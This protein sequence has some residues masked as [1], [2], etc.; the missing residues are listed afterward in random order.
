LHILSRIDESIDERGPS[1][2][3]G[4]AHP[5][6]SYE[7]GDRVSHLPRNLSREPT[8]AFIEQS[9]PVLDAVSAEV[10][11][12]DEEERSAPQPTKIGRLAPLHPHD[13]FAKSFVFIPFLHAPLVVEGELEKSLHERH[14]HAAEPSLP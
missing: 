14:A 8:I 1:R 7:T 12:L 5:S 3:L 9:A 4:G 11:D 13:S 6:R 2:L 10:L